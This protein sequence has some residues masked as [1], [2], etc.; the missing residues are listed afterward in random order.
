MACSQADR[1][2]GQRRLERAAPAQIF[3]EPRHVTANFGGAHEELKRPAQP[4]ALAG[5]DLVMNFS[6]RRCHL[7]DRDIAIT[8]HAVPFAASARAAVGPGCEITAI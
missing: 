3:A 2:F 1:Q 7:L 8:A 5:D 6:L 4:A